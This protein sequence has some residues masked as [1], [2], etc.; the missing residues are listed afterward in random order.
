M[1]KED[2]KF[3]LA[4]PEY[5]INIGMVARVLRNFGFKELRIVN[6]QCPIDKTAFMFAK[7]GKD[8]LERAK[9]Y[10][11]VDDAVADCKFVIGTTGVLRRHK[12]TVRN[13]I[14]LRTFKQR[15]FDGKVALLFGREGIGL[16]EEEINKC[17]FHVTI[18]TDKEYPI[19]NLSH[20]V[21][22]TAYELSG[23][24]I[25]ARHSKKNKENMFRI[26]DMLVD[27]LSKHL[28]NPDKFKIVF[29]RVVGRAAIRDD[30]INV[31]TGLF[32]YIIREIRRTDKVD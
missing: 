28:E 19:L 12:R 20:A 2:I 16:T 4:E 17:D 15:S 30:E 6:P 13:P 14:D 26:Y 22:I 10:A 5:P 18:P 8:L 9:V 21:A 25:V 27:S 11:T 23:F 32:S 3:V 31:L 1:Q 29:R 24:K 7:H